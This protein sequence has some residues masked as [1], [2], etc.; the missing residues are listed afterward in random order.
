MRLWEE[1]N[2]WGY[3]NLTFQLFDTNGTS[4][5]EIQ[6]IP[7][8]WT[9]NFPCYLELNPKQLHVID[10]HLNPKTWKV[11]IKPMGNGEGP[12]KYG[13][14]VTYSVTKTGESDKHT[15]WTGTL[16]SRMIPVTLGY[17]PNPSNQNETKP[18]KQ[19]ESPDSAG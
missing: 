10:V 2:S 6:K 1:W 17:W 11:P 9:M 8:A 14:V 12:N 16:K 13:L 18:R 5:S 15:V 4:I 3:F 19:M 7:I